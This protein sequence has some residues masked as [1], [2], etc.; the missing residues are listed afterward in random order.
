M[1]TREL[2]RTGIEVSAYCLGTMMFG[3]LGNPDHDDCVRMTH[4][5][6]DAGINFLRPDGLHAPGAAQAP[7]RRPGRGLTP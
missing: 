4:R 5:A 3:P 2:G 1:R 6:P 7:T